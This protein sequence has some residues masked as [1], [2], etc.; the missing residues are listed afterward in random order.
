MAHS[1]GSYQSMGKKFNPPQPYILAFLRLLRVRL[2]QPRQENGH[3]WLN[4]YQEMKAGL[5]RPLREEVVT[6]ILEEDPRVGTLLYENILTA[7]ES[8]LYGCRLFFPKKALYKYWDFDDNAGVWLCLGPLLGLVT[9]PQVRRRVMFFSGLSEDQVCRRLRELR[10]GVSRAEY[11]SWP[12]TLRD[13]LED[14][15]AV[16]DTGEK[17]FLH[18][19]FPV[20]QVQK[21]GPPPEPEDLA[22]FAL[23]QCWDKKPEGLPDLPEREEWLGEFALMQAAYEVFELPLG[24]ESYW[25]MICSAF[26]EQRA[27]EPA[28]A[29]NESLAHDAVE[30]ECPGTDENPGENFP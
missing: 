11:G 17:H 3:A 5:S 18:P 9:H 24:P 1:W 13:V 16:A 19:R 28:S 6:A 8:F 4:V 12:S 20:E 7:R 2:D 22:V 27:K 14:L 30:N 29:G 10:A 23:E 15:A 21:D 25:D 26:Q